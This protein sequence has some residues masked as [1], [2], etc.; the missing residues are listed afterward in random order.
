MPGLLP[1]SLMKS[2]AGRGA[3]ETGQSLLLEQSSFLTPR[4]PKSLV[5]KESWE[6]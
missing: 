6:L 5:G 3:R 2:E 1:W 4:G